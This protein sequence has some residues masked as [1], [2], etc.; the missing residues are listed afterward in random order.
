MAATTHLSINIYIY[1]QHEAQGF[2]YNFLLVY[3][4][5]KINEQSN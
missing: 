5:K 4:R 1:L 3:M 2:F